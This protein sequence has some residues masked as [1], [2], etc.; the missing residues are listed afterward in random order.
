MTIQAECIPRAP[1]CFLV[2]GLQLSTGCTM[3]NR[4]IEF[5]P[6]SRI[7]VVLTNASTG[8]KVTYVLAEGL[9]TLIE[10]W[11]KTWKSDET[12]ALLIYSVPSE[13]LLFRETK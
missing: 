4:T 9:R 10:E 7:R 13:S 11:S 1:Y 6:S 5:I 8:E 12:V 3:G 2:D